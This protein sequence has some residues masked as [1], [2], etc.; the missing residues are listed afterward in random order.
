MKPN[1]T[2]SRTPFR[3]LLANAALV[4]VLVFVSS[5]C[6][7]P[8]KQTTIHSLSDDEAYLAQTYAQVLHARD[9]HDVSY[10][11]SDSLFA[12]LDST[13]DTT[14]IANTIRALDGEPDRWIPVFRRILENMDDLSQGQVSEGAR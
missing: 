8:E 12:M 6:S 5:Y 3:S 4:L 2:S 1:L 7:G 14:R 11:E 13:I 10:L 9:L